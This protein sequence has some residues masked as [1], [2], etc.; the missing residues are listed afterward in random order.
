MRIVFFGS[1]R[2]ALPSLERLLESGPSIAFAATAHD[3]PPQTT[4]PPRHKAVNV[5]F[6]LLPKYR[7]A[8]PVQWA[9]LNGEEKT[10]VTVFELNERMD[11]GAIPRQMETAI[12]PRET[13]RE[14][15]G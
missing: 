10:G 14:V 13:A 12:L 8:A 3:P 2:A 5:H 1:S 11:E 6:S 7:G 9:I 15:G 4:H